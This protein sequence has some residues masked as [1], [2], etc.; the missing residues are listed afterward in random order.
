MSS[1]HQI[2]PRDSYRFGISRSN[3]ISLRKKIRN[4]TTGV[5]YLQKA[6]IQK[7]IAGIIIMARGGDVT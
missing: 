1:N 6:T 2:R 3:L 4:K 5:L 7:I